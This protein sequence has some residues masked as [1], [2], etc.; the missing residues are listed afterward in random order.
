MTP[1]AVWAIGIGQCVGWGVL[2]YAFG[3]LLVPVEQ[4]LVSR[5]GSSRARSPR[6]CWSRPSRLQ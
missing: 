5:A 3:V 2:Y 1:R 4:D 6:H